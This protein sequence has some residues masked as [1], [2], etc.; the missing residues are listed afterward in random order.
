M[1]D[2]SSH[3]GRWTFAALNAGA[4]SVIGIEARPELVANAI[5]NLEH[6]G[7]SADRYKFYT[8][9]VFDV[10]AKENIEVDVVLCLGFLYHTLRYNELMSR[11]RQCNPDFLIVDTAVTTGTRAMLQLKLEEVSLQGNAVAD[12]FSRGAAVLSGKPTIKGLRLLAEAYDYDLERFSDWGGL[13]RDNPKENG[14]KDYAHQ[15]RLTARLKARSKDAA[16]T[17]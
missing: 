5:E 4:A 3:D 16:P 2:I 1:L 17:G 6:Y 15:T 14:V 13:V 10:L 11:I 8:G 9:D 7:A 12:E